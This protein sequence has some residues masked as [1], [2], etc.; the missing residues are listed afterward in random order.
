MLSAFKNFFVTFLIAALI[1]GSAA[2]FG[3]R[4][5]TDTIT[6]IF[7]AESSELDSI[8]NP[9]T[10]SGEGEK[11]DDSTSDTQSPPQPE[12]E[13]E[14]DS[15]NALFIITDYQPDIFYDYLPTT[16][17]LN[18][19]DSS[20]ASSFGVLS[21]Q[22]RR[23]RACAI[24]LLRADKER[25]AFTITS[26]PTIAKTTTASGLQSLG[27]LYNLYGRDYIV[28][29][30]SAMTGLE[31]D[32]STMV[33]ITEVSDIVSSIGA[34]PVY[35]SSNLYYNGQVSTNKKPTE[36]E[37]AELPLLYQ[38]GRNQIDGAG[39]IA[40]LMNEDDNDGITARNSLLV[41]LFSG[42][43]DKLTAMSEADLLSFYSSLCTD[44]VIDTTFMPE[45]LTDS[46]DLLYAWNNEAFTKTTLDYPGRSVAATE[47]T[48]AYYQLDSETGVSLFSNYRKILSDSTQK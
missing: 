32:Y 11:P 8:L 19:L 17:T 10:D 21:S 41:S 46:C 47:D 27:D 24:L 5:L 15:F 48:D 26:F 36:L 23:I 28:S 16:T 14:G 2:Y 35:L 6:G 31:I 7:D 30:I 43:L 39:I 42:I 44:G 22:Y 4:F 45:D 40:L 33:N 3:T 25:M 1:F 38:I 34:I 18:S 37:A 12:I 20:G 29:K 9:S 13:L